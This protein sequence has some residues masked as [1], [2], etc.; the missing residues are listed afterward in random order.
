MQAYRIMLD[1]APFFPVS[2]SSKKPNQT[3]PEKQNQPKKNTKKNTTTRKTNQKT[4]ATSGNAKPAAG[5]RHPLLTV[6]WE[7]TRRSIVNVRAQAGRGRDSEF[8]SICIQKHKCVIKILLLVDF[9]GSKR[10]R[11]FHSRRLTSFIAQK[12]RPII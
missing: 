3:K 12:P 1:N 5:C 2:N 8:Q 10:L 7:K 9:F 11:I 4:H 6:L